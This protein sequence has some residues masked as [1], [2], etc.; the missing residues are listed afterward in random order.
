VSETSSKPGADP[1]ISLR[2][3]TRRGGGDADPGGE[4]VTRIPTPATINYA[5]AALVAVA[6]GVVVR[7]LGLLGST[8][9]LQ[10]FVKTANAK[11]KKPK[12]PYT[13]QLIAKDIHAL[14]QGA[15]IEAAVIA[16]AVLL[17]VVALRRVRSASGSRWALLIMLVLTSL[18]FYVVP[19]SGFPAIP[20]VAGVI[21]GVA[22]IAALLLIFVPP[23][24][25]KYFRDCREANTPPELRGQPRPG[26]FG[27]RRPREP[28]G[29]SALGRAA[30]GG[31][32]PKRPANAAKARSKVRS[33]ADAIAHGAELARSR[34]KAAGKSRRSS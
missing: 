5:C 28:R 29:M 4:Q 22:S 33:D 17:L 3:P 7:A 30:A 12:D 23:A 6:V 15:L 14:R 24:S 32:V 11:A 13:A 2:K 16:I 25:Q 19:I 1:R 18:P 26:L 21:V 31:A 27:P 8:G 20:K 9:T 10:A 34:A